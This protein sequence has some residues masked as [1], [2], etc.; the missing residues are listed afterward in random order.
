MLI[1]IIDSNLLIIVLTLNDLWESNKQKN[2]KKN[3]FVIYALFSVSFYLSTSSIGVISYRISS[4]GFSYST[5]A[6]PDNNKREYRGRERERKKREAIYLSCS[7]FCFYIQNHSFIIF[8]SSLSLSL[9]A[10]VNKILS[11]SDDKRWRT[12]KDSTSHRL[13]WL[14]YKDL[15]KGQPN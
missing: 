13:F 1:W 8:F 9:L 6:Y 7:S 12:R 15:Y 5:L 4:S 2:K 3:L 10:V 11:G 14:E